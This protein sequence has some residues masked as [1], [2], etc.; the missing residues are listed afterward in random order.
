MNVKESVLTFTDEKSE[1]KKKLKFALRHAVCLVLGFLFSVSGFGAEFSPL[2]VAFAAACG[3]KY[4]PCA[5]CGAVTGYIIGNDT[6]ISLRYFATLLAVVVIKNAL[7][8]FPELKNSRTVPA[9][10][11]F[12]CLLVTGLAIV[13]SRD[14]TV[15]SV[16]IC[17]SEALLGGTCTLLFSE[18]G[19]LL[20]SRPG[21]S[22]LNSRETTALILAASLLLLSVREVSL[23]GI[24]PAHIVS[25][26]II[27]VCASC[28]HEP[29][30]AV[31]GICSGVAMCFGTGNVFLLALYSFGGLA[32]GAAAAFGRFVSLAAFFL[33][34]I[35]VSAISGGENSDI[36]LL[37]EALIAGVIF[38][39][40]PRRFRK[41]AHK[42]LSPAVPSP[43]IDGIKNEITRRLKNAS[44][45]SA[46]ICASLTGVS[47]ALAKSDEADIKTVYRKTRDT[48]CGSC[49][50]FDS[51][52]SE[53]FDSTQDCFNTLLSMKKEG[54][55][56]EKGNMPQ[57]LVSRCIRSESIAS[58]YNRLYAEFIV[59]QR[60]ESRVN[61]IHTL[62]SQQFVNVSSLLDSLCDFV[63]EEV[64]FDPVLAGKIR[65]AFS[66]CGTELSDV[67]CAVDSLERLSVQVSA[68]GQPAFSDEALITEKLETAVGVGLSLV[69]TAAAAGQTRLFFKQKP[70]LRIVSAG[71]QSCSRGEKYPGDCFTCF[72]TDDGCYYAAVCDGMGTGARAAVNANLAVSLTERL[73]K[74]GFGTEAAIRTVNT[75]LIS[76]SGDECSV[77]LDLAAVDLFTGHV[78]FYK[79]GAAPSYIKK[80]GNITDIGLSS[81]PLGIL[82]EP[83]SVNTTAGVGRGDVLV[84]ASDGVRDEDV[85]A[86]KESLKRF[87][88]GN[89]RE[90]TKG[91]HD[92]IRERQ[93]GKNDDLTIVTLAV[94]AYD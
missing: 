18:C 22:L 32:A 6:V 12:V 28:A 2:G 53:S 80:Q 94:A 17:L 86:L 27:L 26:V 69:Q 54:V 34:G 42:L 47:Q 48:V 5:V 30:G 81:L 64:R 50:L 41:K 33:A 3:Q 92:A 8:A 46:E 62:A 76:K 39:L 65:A 4:L 85:P 72:E 15:W 58:N 14:V 82:S 66:G 84:L 52:W 77:T 55:F 56:L 20:K 19:R 7:R 61:E 59:K 37:A 60:L 70:K 91:L 25:V 13:F 24:F 73:I 87:S 79:C 57:A 43:M 71:V 38:V 44:G 9:V 78:T 16:L 74:A 88:G 35:A 23:F 51:C 10:G 1:K 67:C 89:V 93:L 40:L 49:G 36:Y 11:A 29:G 68:A 31:T 90:F 21:L 83:D 75:S 63:C 45:I